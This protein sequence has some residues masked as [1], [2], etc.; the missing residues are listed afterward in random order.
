M[1]KVSSW[2]TSSNGQTVYSA[3]SSV[4]QPV[5]SG[6][7]T[8]TAVFAPAPFTVTAYPATG[9]TVRANGGTAATTISTTTKDGHNE[10]A[11]TAI[12]AS[13]YQLTRWLLD[14]QE[15]KVNNATFTGATIP[16]NTIPVM[17]GSVLQ[18]VFQKNTYSIR[19][20]QNDINRG[21]VSCNGQTTNSGNTT[22]TQNTVSNSNA[23]KKAS[24]SITA[25]ET[26]S[27]YKFYYWEVSG[28]G[29]V[30]SWGDNGQ[31]RESKTIQ[32]VVSGNVTLKAVFLE[33]NRQRTFT[34]TVND[35]NLGTIASAYEYNG[36]GDRIRRVNVPSL[37]GCA[38]RNSPYNLSN[39][40]T[41]GAKNGSTFLGWVLYDSNGQVKKTYDS[42]DTSHYDAKLKNAVLGSTDVQ[43]TEASGMKLVAYFRAGHDTSE[44]GNVDPDTQ[45]A[46]E[47]METWLTNL[48]TASIEDVSKTAQVY[49]Y[50]NRIYKIDLSASSGQK[51]ADRSILI[52]FITDTSRSM[53]FPANLVAANNVTLSSSYRLYNWLT[54]YGGNGTYYVIAKKSTDATMYT[55]YKDGNDWYYV[56]A[57]YK[58]VDDGMT[59]AGTKITANTNLFEDMDTTVYRAKYSKS[60]TDL[61]SRLDFL[62]MAVEKAAE[63][64][65]EICPN[66]QIDITTFNKT[67]EYKGTLPKDQAGIEA[68]LRTISVG[69]GTQQ[70]QGLDEAAK[71]FTEGSLKKQVAVL[72]T[73]GAPNK[74][75]SGYD[76]VDELWEAIYDSAED[77][78][79]IPDAS[80]NPLILYALGLSLGS[81]EGAQEKLET[82]VATDAD[83]VFP[84]ET[85]TEI[86]ESLETLVDNILTEVS[87]YGSATE[88]LDSAFYPVDANGNPI[89]AGF[90]LSDGTKVDAAPS[91]GTIYYQW[92]YD[93]SSDTWTITWY[94]QKFDPAVNDIP[95]WSR[96]IYV[97]AKEDFL[98]GNEIKTNVEGQASSVTAEGYYMLDGSE[99]PLIPATANFPLPY[100]NVDELGFTENNTTWT[101]YKGTTVDP[102]EQLRALWNNINVK[103]VV[104]TDGVSADKKT[105]TSGSMQ[106]YEIN[107][108]QNDTDYPTRGYSQLPLI[109]DTATGLGY[110]DNSVFETLLS[111]LKDG[112]ASS[113][114]STATTQIPYAPYG[115]GT[116]GY[117]NVTL[118]KDVNSAA[119]SDNAPGSHVTKEADHNPEETYTITVSYTPVKSVTASEHYTYTTE[120]GSAGRFTDESTST[121]THIINV[122]QKELSI[123]KTDGDGTVLTGDK[124]EGPNKSAE[125]TIFRAA[126]QGETIA[127]D[128]RLP[129]GRFTAIKTISTNPS[130]GIATWD[131]IEGIKNVE[132]T[133]WLEDSEYYI[134]ETKAPGYYTA[135]SKNI[136]VKLRITE[137]TDPVL[138]A[139]DGTVLL[140]NLTQTPTVTVTGDNPATYITEISEVNNVI[141]FKVRNDITADITIIKTDNESTPKN[142][143]GAVFKLSKD[144]EIQKNLT[145][146][147]ASD[148]TSKVTVESETGYFSVPEGGVIIKGLASNAESKNYVLTEVTPPDGYVVT[149]Q[150]IEFT[151]DGTGAVADM[152]NSLNSGGKVTFVDKE[153]KIQNEPGAAL[154]NT[155]GPGT[156]AYTILGSI[157]ILGVG[158]M[159]WRRRRTI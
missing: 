134:L 132:G 16:A 157:L 139:T 67:A 148:G 18:A 145:I 81:V 40:I 61:W 45:Q 153:Y 154:P 35:E 27:S 112:T 90:Y 76:T 39:G 29:E 146:V 20:T 47:D 28:D 8:F 51:G 127:S 64:V 71:H 49:D 88:T 109:K 44:T 121:N 129:E 150:P 136:P 10:F 115:H 57:S 86:I 26:N 80:G 107:N 158:V 95:G 125:F 48:K 52:N 142:I 124:I 91:D 69:G 156:W 72:V 60:E 111:N 75:D 140:Y 65:Y 135:Y 62:C 155:G 106:W 114:Y 131:F 104:K 98:G 23:N 84:S 102:E 11:I 41:A 79:A 151:V 32:P 58:D 128:S 137:D 24:Y 53:Y 36:S 59:R 73:D 126:K 38:G 89:S 144:G 63:V 116:V 96:S 83:H 37:V 117:L 94:H 9:G 123:T 55:V 7:V 147:K 19:M 30:I 33:P 152:P 13:G 159:L 92:S 34:V 85:G 1:S 138:T 101:V 141:S 6:D 110:I 120:G 108:G 133:A 31:T 42:S 14:G 143:G 119:G 97:K 2:G 93:S 77:I 122:V 50:D 46:L 113:S 5:V 87:M 4:I 130:T 68:I 118:S 22:L 74:T 15:V 70:N 100:V 25:N 54:N 99:V 66:A 78:K 82:K 12:P 56:D 3:D 103:Q 21:T 17:S 43:I 105:I 149:I